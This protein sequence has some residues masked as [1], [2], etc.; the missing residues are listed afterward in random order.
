MTVV[1]IERD[2][3]RRSQ[4]TCKHSCSSSIRICQVDS[5]EIA[6]TLSHIRRSLVGADDNILRL[7]IAS[8]QDRIGDGAHVD[9]GNVA[10]KLDED[11]PVARDA[12]LGAYPSPHV[13]QH[14]RRS[15]CPSP[16]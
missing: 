2:L 10:G 12:I 7:G 13:A 14:T 8:A 9:L 1:F 4:A 5:K 16:P 15:T 11:E 6:T 3:M